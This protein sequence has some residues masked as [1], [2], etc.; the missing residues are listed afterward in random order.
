[1]PAKP[2]K[3][4]TGHTSPRTLSHNPQWL[5][6]RRGGALLTPIAPNT[7]P[8]IANT[9]PTNGITKDEDAEHQSGNRHRI[10]LDGLIIRHLRLLPSLPNSTTPPTD[11]DPE[12]NGGHDGSNPTQPS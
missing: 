12:T 11:A 4:S 10:G 2:I 9:N 6:A 3:N 8:R 7:I 1:M 5:I